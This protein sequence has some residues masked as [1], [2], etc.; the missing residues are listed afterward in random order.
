MSANLQAT[1]ML[2]RSIWDAGRGG[3][4]WW[5]RSRRIYRSRARDRG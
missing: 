4:S 3:E 2:K 1:K 5:M